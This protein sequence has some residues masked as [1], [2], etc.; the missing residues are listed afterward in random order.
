MISNNCLKKK[1]RQTLS[2]SANEVIRP[3]EEKIVKIVMFFELIDNLSTGF[4]KDCENLMQPPEW[5]RSLQPHIWRLL[6]PK[7]TVGWLWLPQENELMPR[8]K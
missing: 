3:E 8:Y 4:H 2:I 7:I 1:N 5:L 6:L